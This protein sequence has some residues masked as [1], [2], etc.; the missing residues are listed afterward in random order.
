MVLGRLCRTLTHIRS[1]GGLGW[2]Q[3]RIKVCRAGTG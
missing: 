1:P 3:C 2:G